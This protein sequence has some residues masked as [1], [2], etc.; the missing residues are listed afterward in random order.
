MINEAA[1]IVLSI[2]G[3][4]ALILIYSMFHFWLLQIEVLTD[5]YVV[6]N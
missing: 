1:I 2:Y 4:I 6:L 5:N 3:V